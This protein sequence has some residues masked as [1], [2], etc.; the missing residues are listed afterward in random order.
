MGL[1]RS[2]LTSDKIFPYAENVG[3][4]EEG[5]VL[6]SICRTTVS[7]A[8]RMC[9]KTTKVKGKKQVRVP[10][11]I[12]LTLICLDSLRTKEKY[13]NVEGMREI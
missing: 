8:K 11:L 10:G 3:V 9:K 12:V 7:S 5:N 4:E 1:C 2:V 6:Y 13:G